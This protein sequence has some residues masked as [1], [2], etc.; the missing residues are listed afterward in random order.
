MYSAELLFESLDEIYNEL[1]GGLVATP[2]S[3]FV[4]VVDCVI[5]LKCIAT[6]IHKEDAGNTSHGKRV[7]VTIVG[8]RTAC[9]GLEVAL[10]AVN[11]LEERET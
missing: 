7:V 2:N 4:G 6:L 5:I 11:L 8:Q 3:I 10:F 9:Q 1:E